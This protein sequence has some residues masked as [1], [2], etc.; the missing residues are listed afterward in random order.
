MSSQALKIASGLLLVLLLMWLGSELLS[1]R[2]DDRQSGQLLAPVSA[3]DIDLV[4][5][6]GQE[7]TVAVARFGD[8]WRAN[9]LDASPTR[10]TSLLAALAQPGSS[11]VAATSAAVHQRMGLADSPAVRVTLSNGGQVEAELLFG[12]RGPDGSSY[13]ARAA[14]NDTVYHFNGPLASLIDL[15]L[16]DWRNKI[17][18]NAPPGSITRL[19]GDRGG[20]LLDLAQVEGG[21]QVNGDPADSAAVQQLLARFAPLEASGFVSEEEAG[22]IDWSNPDRTVTLFGGDGRELVRLVMDSTANGYRV[23]RFEGGTVYLLYRW[24][25]DGL[26][27]ADSTLVV[28]GPEN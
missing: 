10:V 7:D 23:R 26:M 25:V 8:A 6:A 11:E 18:V 24:I 9:G 19:Q 27:P 20:S 13:Y 14:G 12:K 4:T 5:V 3:G 21:W 22:T 2:P 16:D 28:T 15:P 1:D 17:I